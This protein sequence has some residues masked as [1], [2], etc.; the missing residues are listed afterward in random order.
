MGRVGKIF[1][2]LGVAV[3]LAMGGCMGVAGDE[4]EAPAPEARL[5]DLPSVPTETPEKPDAVTGGGR[6]A[7]DAELSDFVGM[8]LQDAQ[9]TA[10]AA[11]FY[12]LDDQD[13][14]G[15]RRMLLWDRNWTVCS[16]SPKP[17]THN[18]D[19]VVTLYSVKIGESCP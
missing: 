13:A 9:D 2:G 5:D 3:V 17:G 19:T 1:S 10:Q 4:K 15:Q 7:P 11:G 8:S 16:Q 6:Q 12:M 14:S 18:A